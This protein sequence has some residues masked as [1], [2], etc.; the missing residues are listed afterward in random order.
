MKKIFQTLTAAA[1]LTA[2]MATT[3][4]AATPGYTEDVKGKVDFDESKGNFTASC[5]EAVSGNQYILLVVKGTADSYS[6]T[7]EN[8]LYIDQA[9]ADGAGI[10]FAG[11]IPKTVTDSVVLLGGEFQS[12]TSPMVLGTIKSQYTLGD[13]TEDSKVNGQDNVKLM[14]ALAKLETL[15]STQEKAADVTKDGKVNGQDN[16]KLMRVLA[17]L[18]TLN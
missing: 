14:R 4:F 16:V 7:E 18:E 1:V 5:S 6:V 8:I 9:G 10:T 12:G 2:L 11:F 13:V 15:T 3:A 17:K